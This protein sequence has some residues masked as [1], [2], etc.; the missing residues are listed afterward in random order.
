M[1][2]DSGNLQAMITIDTLGHKREKLLQIWAQND[3]DELQ[4]Y[5][6]RLKII[7]KLPLAYLIF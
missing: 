3:L 2:L 5:A 6:L 1:W 4:S 7:M